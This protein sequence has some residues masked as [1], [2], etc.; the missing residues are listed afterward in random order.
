MIINEEMTPGERAFGGRSSDSRASRRVP[1]IACL[2]ME[3]LHC[4]LCYSQDKTKELFLTKC[5]HLACKTCL[6]KG[7]RGGS[8]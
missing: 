1:R 6:A 3:A 7:K 4:M 2:A 5:G 8:E